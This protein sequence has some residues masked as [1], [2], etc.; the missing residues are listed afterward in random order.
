M[1]LY[2][3]DLI[4]RLAC[5]GNYIFSS[6]ITMSTNDRMF[7]TSLSEQICRTNQGLT[8]KQQSLSLKLIKKYSSPLSLEF[9]TDIDSYLLNPQYR[10]EERV[11]S[12]DKEIKIVKESN[13]EYFIHVLF[14]YDSELISRF[15]DYKNNS[16]SFEYRTAYWDQELRLW[17]FS[18]T[19][20]NILFLS[21]LQGFKKDSKFIEFYKE[22]TTFQESMEYYIPMVVKDESGKFIFKNV[23][24]NIPICSFD[25]MLESLLIAKKYGITCWSEEI[26]KELEDINNDLLKSFLKSDYRTQVAS[27]TRKI[28]L[29][30]LEKIICT[31]ARLCLD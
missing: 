22:I 29:K 9:S 7:F 26:N 8:R 28:E 1:I 25:D 19:E 20:H 24:Q 30:E 15:R 12:N 11:I 17:K 18:L 10:L 5:N 4:H 31:Y 27:R 21:N 23:H 14:P 16:K 6:L 3:E 2:V 13:G